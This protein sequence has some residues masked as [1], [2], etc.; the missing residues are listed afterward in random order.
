MVAME[1][2]LTKYMQKS[3]CLLEI[4]CKWLQKQLNN[5]HVTNK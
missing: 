4:E 1:M 5:A 3:G 2:P